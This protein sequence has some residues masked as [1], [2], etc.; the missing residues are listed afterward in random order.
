LIVVELHGIDRQL[1][2]K[3]LL[4]ESVPKLAFEILVFE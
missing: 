1:M 2:Y 3:E 4:N